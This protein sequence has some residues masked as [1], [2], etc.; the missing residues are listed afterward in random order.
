MTKDAL[1]VDVISASVPDNAVPSERVQ[2]TTQKTR[3]AARNRLF[4]KGPIRL[5]W[6]RDHI[7]CPTDRL[8][9]VLI[10]HADMRKTKELKITN[11]ILRDAGINDRKV[12]YRAV[13]RLEAQ[14]ILVATRKRGARPVIRLLNAPH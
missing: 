10:A 2:T 3:E 9:L 5:R 1:S 14:G 7:S 11:K 6:I 4:L 8:L 13:N 12:A